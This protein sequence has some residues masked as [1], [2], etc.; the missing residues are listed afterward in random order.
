MGFYCIGA[1]SILVPLYLTLKVDISETYSS[2]LDSAW[3]I[4]MTI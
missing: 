1:V 3:F 2:G 4:Q